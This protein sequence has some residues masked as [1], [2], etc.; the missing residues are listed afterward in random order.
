MYVIL[1]LDISLDKAQLTNIFFACCY[2][3]S[4]VQ[5]HIFNSNAVNLFGIG[6][7]FPFQKSSIALWSTRTLNIDAYAHGSNCICCNL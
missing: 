7:F 2:L 3:K 1:C 6:S 5:S 4:K